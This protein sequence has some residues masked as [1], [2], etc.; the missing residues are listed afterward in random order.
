LEKTSEFKGYDIG[1]EYQWDDMKKYGPFSRH[2]RRI[3]IHVIRDVSFQS[4][5]DVGCGQGSFL[6]ELMSKFPGIKINGVELS[7]K[8]IQIA[9]SRIPEGRFIELDITKSHLS[10]SFDLV[11]CSEVLEH[12]QED[13]A[14]LRNLAIMTKKY[15]VVTSPQGRMRK[16]EDSEMGHVRNYKPG[17][18]A[19]KLELNGFRI[20]SLIEWG[21]P[22]YSPLYRNLLELIGGKGTTGKFG[23]TRKLISHVI[24]LLFFLNSSKNGDEVIILAARK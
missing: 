22:F 17:E 9:K 19:E 14:A 3:I 13:I 20:I 12:I 8:A 10:E 4:V 24:Y 11:I 16:F 15:L 1:W 2:L 7:P 23:F 5:M 21:F 18:L 6:I